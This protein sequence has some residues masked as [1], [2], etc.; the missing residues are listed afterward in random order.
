MILSLCAAL[1]DR[2]SM[3]PTL[4]SGL[5]A[6]ALAA[7]IAWIQ[8][9]RLVG[10]G[11]H[12]GQAPVQVEPLWRLNP[13][14]GVDVLS[15]VTPWPQDPGDALVRLHP[16]YLGLSL[17]GLA[18]VGGRGAL[19]WWLVLLAA[20]LAAPADVLS[21]AGRPLGIPN[22]AAA[23]LDLVP[24]GSLV[25]HHGR[26]LL[27]GAVALSVL[28]SRGAARLRRRWGTGA[29]LA[30]VALVLVD[31]VALAPGGA[32]LP[33]ADPTPMGVASQLDSLSPGRLL[34][35]PVAGPGVHPQRPLLD[36]RVHRRPL[37]LDPQRPGLP[38]ALA[39]TQTGRWL[40]GLALPHPPQGPADAASVRADLAGVAVLA[41][42]Q[43]YVSA[44]ADVLG[45]P[46]L[47]AE[48]SAAWDLA[49]R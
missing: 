44:V 1:R 23:L 5:L 43:P 36:Q 37:L 20:V 14:R 27:V 38:V 31:L 11:R 24:G 22:P 17:L 49:A 40:G 18:V 29:I 21:F 28:A 15:L 30:A 45:P 35:L 13:L 6:A 7:P 9:A 16:G 33:T 8:G 42:R 19:R 34:V 46:D 25:N 10:A 12:L 4:L 48:D 41:V 32:P 2:R 39:S 26:L 3:G 47:S